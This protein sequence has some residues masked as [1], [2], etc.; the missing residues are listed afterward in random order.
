MIIGLESPLLILFLFAVSAYASSVT[1]LALDGSYGTTYTTSCG[2]YSYFKVY[3]TEPCK[4]LTVSTSVS[5]GEPDIYVSKRST[6]TKSSLSWAAYE[7]GDYDVTISHWDPESSPGW[8]YISIYADCRTKNTAA[9][10]KIKTTLSSSD[11]DDLYLYPSKGLLL[12]S[13]SSNIIP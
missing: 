2:S 4:D 7:D 1:T 10:Y 6:P 5:A 8:Y 11:S 3:M 9:V 13:I 12:R